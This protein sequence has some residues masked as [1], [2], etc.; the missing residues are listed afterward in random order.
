MNVRAVALQQA[1]TNPPSQLD[2]S[3][4]GPI[5]KF[6][7]SDDVIRQLTLEKLKR[8]LPLDINDAKME[9]RYCHTGTIKRQVCH[10]DGIDFAGIVYLT[11]PEHCQGG[12]WFFRHRPTGDVVRRVER[13]AQY[14]YL[15][16]EAWEKT[17][18]VPM[19]FNRLVL[20]PGDLFHAIA[21]P[22]FGDCAENARLAYTFFVFTK[23]SLDLQKYIENLDR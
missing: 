15:A 2:A 1:Y 18:E 13:Q 6:A 3:A 4:S 5:A 7:V 19:K 23:P 10:A 9:Y 14:N 12:T 20:Y 16:E 22:Y 17:H 8:L 11:L 21:T